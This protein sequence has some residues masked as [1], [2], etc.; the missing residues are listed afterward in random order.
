MLAKISPRDFRSVAINISDN[1]KRA[2]S[3]VWTFQVIGKRTL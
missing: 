3:S 1:R 2:F